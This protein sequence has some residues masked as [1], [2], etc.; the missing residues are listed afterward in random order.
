[1][2]SPLL[3]NPSQL[4]MFKEI[5]RYRPTLETLNQVDADALTFDARRAP[6][7]CARSAK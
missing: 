5:Q 7:I 4:R 3:G 1:V 2:V 6:V